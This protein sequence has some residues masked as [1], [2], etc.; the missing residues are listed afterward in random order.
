VCVYVGEGGGGSHMQDFKDFT[1]DRVSYPE[2]EVR[3]FV[4][5]LHA[6]HQR[7]VLIVDPAIKN[8]S[9]YAAPLSPRSLGWWATCGAAAP[10][11]SPPYTSI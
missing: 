1:F 2:A 11:L 8:E 7:N 4:D 10:S 3:A 5:E 9:G 6:N